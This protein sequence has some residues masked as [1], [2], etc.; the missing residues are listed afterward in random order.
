[1]TRPPNAEAP[2]IPPSPALLFDT[3]NAYQKTAAIKAAIELDLFTPLANGPMTSEKIAAYIKASP[4]G[5]RI[6]CDYLTVLGFLTK[7]GDSY[8]LTPDS[9]VFL[10]R[11]SPAYA[12]RTIEFLLGEHLRSAFDGLTDSVRTGT[13]QL[14][15]GGSLA[16][17]H[18]MWLA[19]ARHMGALMGPAAD[20]LASLLPL[21]L[22]RPAKVLDISASHGVWGLAFA[23]KY[24]NAHVV[25]LDWK[26]VL[27]IARENASR[28][29]VSDRF[30]TIAGSAFDVDLGSE[31][32]V[33]LV[34]NFLHHFDTTE[35]VR[36]LK[37]AHAAMRPGGSIAIV[38][39]V[40]NEDRVSPPAAATFALVML[41]TTPAGDA[42]T[43]VEYADMLHRAGFTAPTQHSLPGSMNVAVVARK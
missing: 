42:Y 22:G 31:Y 25:A 43:F 2:G 33:V 24:P 35:C 1:M 36:F 26:P 11:N 4:R 16:P 37:R 39:F 38:E 8:A 30:S 20:G 29:G 13:A 3:I 19:F 7:A 28:A 21:E 12:G 10:V 6:L 17:D 27:E 9:A 15:E 40:P 14:S 18:P 5:V 32:D 23:K 34:P 41:A